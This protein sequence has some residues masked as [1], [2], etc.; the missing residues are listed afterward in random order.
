MREGEGSEDLLITGAKG[1]L[2]MEKLLPC[3]SLCLQTNAYQSMSYLVEENVK[4]S[5]PI[6]NKHMGNGFLDLTT[7]LR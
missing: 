7:S 3:F 6:T 1:P 5:L 2:W 4:L